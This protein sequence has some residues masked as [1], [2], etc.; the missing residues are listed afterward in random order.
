M[1]LAFILERLL[2]GIFVTIEITL[3]AALLALVLAF[4]AGIARLSPNPLLSM[5]AAVYVEIFRGTSALIQLFWLFYA[6]PGF[7]I[8]LQPFTVAVVGLGLN[9]GAYGSEVV[10]GA[11]LAVPK[12]QG[13]AGIALNLLARQ[14][15]VRI[16]LPQAIPAML[17][18]FG[19]LLIQLLKG[20]A[21]V[22]LITISDITFEAQQIRAITGESVRIYSLLLVLYF[23]LALPLVYMV[24]F[25]EGRT[26]FGYEKTE[27]T[28]Q[29]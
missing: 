17:P 9:V 10:R 12:G 7:G 1:T 15:M 6:L 5:T 24:R 4:T 8:T 22:S 28:N 26:R 18:P 29:Q 13:D 3:F 20:T 11:I 21:L 14:R 19:N 23:L 16:I 25:F 2:P 27:L